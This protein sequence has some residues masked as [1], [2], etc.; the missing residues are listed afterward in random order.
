MNQGK[1]LIAEKK[2]DEHKQLMEG[3]LARINE[4]IGAVE[5][6][7]AEEGRFADTDKHLKSLHD[8]LQ[9][10]REEEQTLKTLD[11]VR[12]SREYARAFLK[13][14]ATGASV[15]RSRAVEGL[16]PLY[17][18][19]TISGGDPAGSDG[20]FLVPKEFDN[21]I[22]RASK[23]YLDLSTLF[24]VEHVSSAS[25]WRAVENGVPKA[26]PCV[27]EMGT[28][29]KTDQPKFSIVNY[30]VKKY[31]DRLPISSEL[32]EDESAGLLAY[33]ADWFAP[34][35]VLTKNALLLPLL[36]GLTKTV[37][38]TGTPDKVLR[39]ALVKQLNTAHSRAATLLTNQSGYAEMDGWEDGNKRSLLV[40]DA[41][42][43]H[44]MRYRNRPVVY[45]DDTELTEKALYVGNFK[46]LGTLFVRKGIEMATTNVGGDA[47][48]T[49]ST[50][51]RVICRLDAQKVFEDAAFKATF[52]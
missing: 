4:E 3:D 34:K 19:L 26:M 43:D 2:F 10:Q 45:G 49:D 41:T 52:A 24:N 47:W 7:L 11:E 16:A 17:K 51:A 33:V 48:A 1:Q 18:A 8:Q 14:M 9:Q 22:I 31:A 42:A 20:G 32:L 6:Q 36:T 28:I 40:P 30:S 39:Q 23:E 27:D 15:K 35:Y 12:G 29:G 50:E 25:G 37:E 5:K 44:V 38:L 46:A 13:A 21:A